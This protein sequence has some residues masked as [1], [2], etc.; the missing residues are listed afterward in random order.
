MW[1]IYTHRSGSHVALCHRLLEFRYES[2]IVSREILPSFALA[3]ERTTIS[4]LSMKKVERY[5][6]R[7]VIS[8]VSLP[9][10]LTF[11][12]VYTIVVQDLGHDLL[13]YTATRRSIDR[14]DR[15]RRSRIRNVINSLSPH[16]PYK[17]CIL[18]FL[19]NRVANVKIINYC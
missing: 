4:L 7:E 8:R 16:I 5:R 12:S 2:H 19:N 9:A 14:F 17:P 3:G 13:N 18:L 15:A 10:S 6:K 11:D 1:C